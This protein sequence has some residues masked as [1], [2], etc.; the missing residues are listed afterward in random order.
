MYALEL[1]QNRGDIDSP[2]YASATVD[3]SYPVAGV[4]THLLMGQNM[5]VGHQEL[6]GPGFPRLV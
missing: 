2:W 6:I 3:Q 5:K 1:H 4:P